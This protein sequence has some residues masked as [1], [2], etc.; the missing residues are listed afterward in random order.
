M[1]PW[2][3]SGRRLPLQN[4]WAE[5]TL[6]EDMPWAMLPI[7]Q[8]YLLLLV[9]LLTVGGLLAGLAGHLIR[10][11]RWAVHVGVLV[12]QG[13][14]AVQSLM[15]VAGGLNT[16]DT[17]AQIYLS[18]MTSVVLF[19]MALTHMVIWLILR[20]GRAS[21]AIA[22]GLAAFPITEWITEWFRLAAGPIGA[23]VEV[24]T[25][26]PW[27]PALIAGV[28][29]GWCGWR[30][31]SRLTA[32]VLNLLVLWLGSALITA[33]QMVAGSR[34]ILG[35]GAE[36]V[37]AF[38]DFLLAGLG[39]AGTGLYLLLAALAIA[40]IVFALRTVWFRHRNQSGPNPRGR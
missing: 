18:A 13:V 37:T 34:A 31:P 19:G 5:Q 10:A 21:T 17:R 29:L 8:Y 23:P 35:R 33:V 22:V 40:L 14:A 7:N 9:A 32:W 26:M 30:P 3:F 11:P 1:G 36:A 16:A 25:W 38:V 20:N 6:P 4:L 28:A 27:L 24:T 39:P 2:L 15:V 12:I